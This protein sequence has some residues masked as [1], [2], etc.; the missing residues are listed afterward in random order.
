MTIELTA[1]SLSDAADVTVDSVDDAVELDADTA[2]VVSEKDYNQLNN[3]PSIE[4]TTITGEMSLSDISAYTQAE[5]DALL[6]DKADAD[7]I[8]TVPTAV[9]AFTNDAGYLTEHQ[10]LDG[11]T[12]E[13]YV[14]EALS[15]YATQAWVESKGYLT[16]HQDISG[17]ANTADLAAV[18]TSG[19][20]SDLSDTPT[21][22]TKL[23]AFTD[24][25]GSSPT[26]THSQYLT[27]HQ[28]LSAYAKSADLADVAT[29]G[30]YNDLSDT[31]TI[32]TVPTNVSA[33]TNDAGYLT[34]HQDISGKA[35]VGHT[36]TGDEVV[37]L[38]S[39][40]FTGVLATSSDV[41]TLR[42]F[43]RVIPTDW[44]DTVRIDYRFKCYVPGH[45]ELYTQDVECY[46]IFFHNTVAAY[47]TRNFIG[48]TSYR[49]IYYNSLMRCKEA[50]KSIGH[51]V[52]INFY[53]AG[54][55]YSRESTT[56]GYERTF[57]IEILRADN[58]T[59]EWLDTCDTVAETVTDYV[60]ST[61]HESISNYNGTTQG[62]THSGDANSNTI[63]T[64]Y[65]TTGA[66][67]AAKVATCNYGYRGDTAYFPC[68]FR[69]A[70]TASNATLAISSYATTALPI[71]VNG[72][73]TTS[74]NTFSAG[75]HIFLY[76]DSAYYM[77]NDGRFPILYNGEVTSIQDVLASLSA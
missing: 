10:S 34:E 16:A 52:G 23:S 21:I 42:P 70:N 71:Y 77:Y 8:P 60:A 54:N 37:A 46:Y 25:L 17:K 51:L 13:Y 72:A 57:E 74:S 40:T 24:D 18:A 39:K 32:P 50:Y 28:S 14:D 73:R 2:I 64:G 65:C 43:F 5:V 45:E 15:G 9:S 69:Y 3:L 53:N 56:T 4:G 29:S 68:L 44:D 36:H 26:H 11:Y 30:S 12:T 67:T 33:F 22:P 76:Y 6:A 38:S 35:D 62:E 27:S 47:C 61:T 20:Y 49:P 59:I 31:P 63:S 7:D 19:S 48:S 66:S 1:V 55:N 58:C 41:N 75:I